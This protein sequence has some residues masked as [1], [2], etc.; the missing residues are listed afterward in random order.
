MSLQETTTEACEFAP[1]WAQPSHPNQL[2][3]RKGD[4]PYS[5]SA[6][7]LVNLPAGSH[8]AK[9]DTAT[10]AKHTTYTSVANGKNCRIE[11]NSDLVYCNHSCRPSLIFDMSRF[12]VR[13]ADDRPLAIGDELTFFYPSTE[14]EMVQPFQCN[15]GAQGKCRG[16]ISGAANL[17]TSILSQYWLNQHIRDLLQDREQR[18][19]G[20]IARSFVSANA[21]SMDKF[22]YTVDGVVELQTGLVR[23]GVLQR[24]ER[25]E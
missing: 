8:F 22:N 16:L 3:V 6:R 5:S 20:D 10:E 7:S 2:E 19:N 9:I 18:A 15:C 14:W 4:E 25:E 17:E 13:V 23:G 12:E 21:V 11:L 1:S 24:T